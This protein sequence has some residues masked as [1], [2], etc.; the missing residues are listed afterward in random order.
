MDMIPITQV[1]M[2]EEELAAVTQVLGS[3]WL[4]QGEQVACFEEQLAKLAGC[5]HGVATTSCTTALHLALAALGVGVGDE[6]IVPG[7]TWVSTANA[8]VFCGA[9]PVFCDIDPDTYNIDVRLL[10]DLVTPRT[11]GVIPVHLFGLC[12]DMDAVQQ[13]ADRHELWVLEDSA[14]G[15]GATYG[16]KAAGSLGD[17]ACF[18]F[19]PRKS[20]TMGEGGA[21]TTSDSG[22]NSRLCILRNHGADPDAPRGKGQVMPEFTDV[23]FNYRLTDL[24]AAVGVVQLK[25]FQGFLTERRQLASL[26]H[27]RLKDCEWLHL[28]EDGGDGWEHAYQSYVVGIR[29]DDMSLA[30]MASLQSRRNGLMNLLETEGIATRPGTHAPVSLACHRKRWGLSA[31]AFPQSLIAQGTT[32]ALPFYPGMGEHTIDRVTEVLLRSW[33][34]LRESI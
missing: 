11:V 24:Q 31:E 14:C 8:V 9:K 21:V 32:L 26:Y 25:R 3:G 23:G 18:S 22:L 5:N 27:D 12:A 33:T 7:F 1:S 34:N 17:A 6:V 4:A 20:V 10:E 30:A 16:H 19:H 15:L 29:G 28:P 2:G 13:I